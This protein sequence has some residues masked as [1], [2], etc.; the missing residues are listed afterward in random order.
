MGWARSLG[1]L[2]ALSSLGCEPLAQGR[3]PTESSIA[4][5][6]CPDAG[7]ADARCAVLSVEE[8]RAAPNGRTI[9]LAIFVAPATSRTPA[10]DPVLFLAGGPGQGAA[11]LAPRILHRFDAI[12]RDRD[13]VFVDV[14][15]TGRSNRLDCDADDPEDLADVLGAK[16]DFDALD[17]CVARYGGADLSQY[18]SSVMIEDLDDV[19]AGL[20]YDQVNLLGI[21]YGT[22][23]AQM[24]M[25]RYPE[26]VRGAILDGVVPTDAELVLNLP[27]NAE[28]SLKRVLADCREDHDCAATFPGLER[29]LAAVL[30]DLETNRRLEAFA[31]PRTGA[32][33]RVE[34]TRAGFTN[35][36]V[37]TLYGGHARALIP[38]LIER[39]HAGDFAPAAAQILDSAR[40][41]KTVAMGLYFSVACAE[42]L[43]SLTAAKRREASRGLEYFDDR[44]LEL[45]EQACA[46]WPHAPLDPARREPVTSA[47]PT[48]ILSGAYDPV[49]PP[50]FGEH[51]ARSLADARHV[52]V[53]ELGHGVW[54]YACAPDLMAAF[55]ASLDTQAVDSS[56]LDALRRPPP[57]LN[58][59]GP[60]LRREPSPSDE[61]PGGAGFDPPAE[62]PPE[63]AQTDH[64]TGETGER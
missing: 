47:A 57:F 64:H 5:G 15:G 10:A 7:V 9:E 2:A 48:L 46:R 41:Q 21:S 51:L 17:D 6:P 55:F 53:P 31:H 58:A 49:T 35:V 42:D 38:M 44:T 29:K 18:T 63:L 43:T 19:R 3:P 59:N 56:C 16:L 1:L 39:A 22:L 27:R 60:W 40:T 8:D 54:S 28:A 23:V 11:S 32:P 25:A 62:A 12:R 24:Y 36:L 20:G 14:R 26:R 50:H 61:A 33:V 4:L 30:T 45:L 13:I 52:V 34:I 37:N